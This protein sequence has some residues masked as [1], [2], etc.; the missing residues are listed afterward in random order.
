MS[1]ENMINELEVHSIFT[2]DVINIQTCMHGWFT[3]ECC[4]GYLDQICRLCVWQSVPLAIR[5]Q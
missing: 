4:W 3:K 1:L 2:I 5:D